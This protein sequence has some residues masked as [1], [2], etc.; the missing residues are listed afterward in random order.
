MVNKEKLVIGS[1]ETSALWSF[2]GLFMC[3]EIKGL[4]GEMGFSGSDSIQHS[5]RRQLCSWTSSIPKYHSSLIWRTRGTW[6]TKSSPPISQA[7]IWCDGTG[8]SGTCS[9]TIPPEFLSS[10]G[11]SDGTGGE[12]TQHAE[13]FLGEDSCSLGPRGIPAALSSSPTLPGSAGVWGGALKHGNHS[14]LE[15]ERV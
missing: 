7:A 15:E 2:L 4:P 11:S 10:I 14:Q 12:S 5:W 1:S 9:L 13:S 3:F 6:I 8:T